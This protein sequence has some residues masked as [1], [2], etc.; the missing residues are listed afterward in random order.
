MFELAQSVL[1]IP[2]W[3]RQGNPGP[4]D[5]L[6]P[7]PGVGCLAFLISTCRTDRQAELPQL[8]GELSLSPW[9]LG[10]NCGCRKQ[11]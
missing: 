8:P 11:E 4:G 7:N 10:N 2:V 5:L 6:R 3:Y 9:T 1:S